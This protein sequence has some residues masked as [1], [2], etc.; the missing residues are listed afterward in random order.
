MNWHSQGS[1]YG[2]AMI[3]QVGLIFGKNWNGKQLDQIEKEY[4]EIFSGTV[5]NYKKQKK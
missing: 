3:G 5:E 1:I 2:V 4:K